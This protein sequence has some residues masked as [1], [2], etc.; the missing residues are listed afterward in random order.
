MKKV[1]CRV[2]VAVNDLRLVE[3]VE[4]AVIQRNTG[5]KI[6]A[7]TVEPPVAIGS[8]FEVSFP[9]EVS[10]VDVARLLDTVGNIPVT[11]AIAQFDEALS[12]ERDLEAKDAGTVALAPWETAKDVKDKLKAVKGKAS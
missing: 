8:V 9:V 11:V 4:K 12:V 1:V 5:A 10:A 7:W 3:L 2:S 6:E